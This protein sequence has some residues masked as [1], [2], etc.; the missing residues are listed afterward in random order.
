VDEGGV[1]WVAGNWLV[2]AFTA[3]V[4]DVV[5]GSRL[6]RCIPVLANFAKSDI[7]GR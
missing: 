7:E 5:R 3:F 4:E 6:S 2:F 1:E